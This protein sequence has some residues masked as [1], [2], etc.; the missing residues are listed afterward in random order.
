MAVLQAVEGAAETLRY[1]VSLWCMPF[2]KL[3]IESRYVSAG[4]CRNQ[5]SEMDITPN[6][7]VL[8]C[9]VLDITL[10]EVRSKAILG[11]WKEQNKHSM[12]KSVNREP[13]LSKPCLDCPLRRKCKGGCYARALLMTE[14]LYS[15]DPLCPRVHG[16]L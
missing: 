9:D 5:V 15:P 14:D 12:T 13:E 11:A 16:I 7:D 3:V 6:G 8:L 10:S 4:F 1:P 2:A